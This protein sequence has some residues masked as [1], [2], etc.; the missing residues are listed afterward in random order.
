MFLILCGTCF[1]RTDPNICVC[2]APIS[3]VIFWKGMERP[4][5]CVW[6]A[7]LWFVNEIMLLKSLWILWL[8]MLQIYRFFH[9]IW[10]YMK[11]K[12][13]SPEI[14]FIYHLWYCSS[15][16][17]PVNNELCTSKFVVNFRNP[18]IYFVVFVACWQL[19]IS[20]GTTRCL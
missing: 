9:G 11:Q 14:I 4:E 13:L 1:Q 12:S 16:L 18:C 10:L 5:R 2:S 7:I 17:M 15:L 6:M 8:C 19:L 3:D 20:S